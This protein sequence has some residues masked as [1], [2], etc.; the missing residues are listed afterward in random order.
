[1]RAAEDGHGHPGA[2]RRGDDP[3]GSGLQLERVS[4]MLLNCLFVLSVCLSVSRWTW[5]GLHPSLSERHRFRRRMF[6]FFLSAVLGSY[7]ADR[8][9]VHAGLVE[10]V[11]LFLT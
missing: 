10:G 6:S 4:G 3:V 5:T 9:D 1:M 11:R 8:T 7:F 2:G